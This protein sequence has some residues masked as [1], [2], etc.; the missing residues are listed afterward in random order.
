MPD[1]ATLERAKKD[2]RE[3]KAPTTQAG[4]FVREEIE[5]KAWH[6]GIVA[7]H[8]AAVL[9]RWPHFFDLHIAAPTGGGR[10]GAGVEVIRRECAAEGELHVRVDIDAAGNDVLAGGIDALRARGLEALPDHGDL[11]TVDE[12]VALVRVGRSHDRPV[13]DERLRHVLPSL[14]RRES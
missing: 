4:E 13:R 1:K 10:D 8:F 3:G 2:K 9:M 6:A 5:Q 7:Q 12:D 14:T 11:L